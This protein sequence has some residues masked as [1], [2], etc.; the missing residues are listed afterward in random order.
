[1]QIVE[2]IA[3]ETSP[4]LPLGEDPDPTSTVNQRQGK[5]PSAEST[6]GSPTATT[7]L[8]TVDNTLDNSTQGMFKDLI[9][10]CCSQTP[11]LPFSQVL[12]QT[13]DNDDVPSTPQLHLRL[14]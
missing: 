3:V 12:H 6:S 14:G 1:M 5:D 2:G 8:R 11:S 7:P 9:P 4:N 10:Q 13:E